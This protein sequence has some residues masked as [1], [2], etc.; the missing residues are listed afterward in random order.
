VGYLLLP[1]D[2]TFDVLPL[3]ERGG[4]RWHDVLNTA[5][6]SDYG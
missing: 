6:D 5:S 1:R 3:L 2:Q 4:P